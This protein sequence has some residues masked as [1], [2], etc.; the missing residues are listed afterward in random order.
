MALDDLG[1]IYR[2]ARLELT[3]F[4]STCSPQAASVQV[5]S[6]PG[7][8]VKD[9]V[10][11]IVGIADDAM[12]GRLTGPPSDAQTAGQVAVFADRT[13]ED[14]LAAWATTGPVFE[15]ALTG[16]GL[17]FSAAAMDVVTH[18]QDIRGA[19]GRPGGRD[20]ETARWAM[21]QTADRL[22]GLANRGKV[23]PLRLVLDG[24]EELLGTDGP[25]VS[26]TTTSF[27]LFRASLGRR[28]RAQL[29]SM[30]WTG[31]STAHVAVLPIFGPTPYDIV[32]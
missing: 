22:R 19:L 5:P 27:E 25:E 18:H 6:T 13:Y 17:S 1:T 10:A 28:S 31:D 21:A 2:D 29:E 32:E 30:G 26:L 12:N 23:P 20:T 14:V 15:Q 11:H 9:V 8:S 16:L 7:W 4:L 24:N 3:A